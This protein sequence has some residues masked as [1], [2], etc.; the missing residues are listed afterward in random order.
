MANPDPDEEGEGID[1]TPHHNR[2]HSWLG[3]R[4]EGAGGGGSERRRAYQ[5]GGRGRGRLLALLSSPLLSSQVESRR[6]ARDGGGVGKAIQIP[7]TL[8]ALRAET[9][10]FH[11][12]PPHP[13]RTERHLLYLGL[14]W[15]HRFS[16]P[17]VPAPAG[18]QFLLLQ[19]HFF[20]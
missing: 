14:G 18:G 12:T 2:S 1:T 13:T 8:W 15:A 10:S 17:T 7:M 6:S 11:P 19:N 9:F 3:K 20:F 16:G 4:R 5:R